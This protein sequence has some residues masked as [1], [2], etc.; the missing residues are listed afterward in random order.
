MANGKKILVVDDDDSICELLK[1]VLE[2][3]GLAVVIARD[4]E[5]ALRMA[6]AEMPD[7]ILLD[8]MLP[9]YGG[10][11]VLRQLQKP[12]TGKIP[13]IVFTG[14]YTDRSTQELIRGESNVI[15]FVE[16]PLN[17]AALS[18]RIHSI[19]KTSPPAR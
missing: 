11:E 16:K 13:I 14:R 9:R 8:L 15:D 19:L 7:L 3:E 18:T 17:T 2:R 5:E 12:G 6:D 4:G 10:F 1:F